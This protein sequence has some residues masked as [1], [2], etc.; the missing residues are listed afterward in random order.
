MNQKPEGFL[1]STMRPTSGHDA[2]DDT[3][4]V[5][6]DRDDYAVSFELSNDQKETLAA[7]KP[8]AL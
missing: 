1:K 7:K 6:G 4:D 5:Q 8:V 3:T 2:D